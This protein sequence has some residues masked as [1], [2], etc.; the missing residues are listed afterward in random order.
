MAQIT[1]RFGRGG[2]PSQAGGVSQVFDAYAQ[3]E[4]LSSSGTSAATTIT[5]TKHD[6]ARVTNHDAS[7]LVWV[8]FGAS[9]TAAVGTTHPIAPGATE[10]L[11]AIGEGHK[12][13]VIDDS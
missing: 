1:V 6:V 5:A 8:T 10:D 3:V 7:Q 11:G 13:A 12:M 9:P 4:E 2:A